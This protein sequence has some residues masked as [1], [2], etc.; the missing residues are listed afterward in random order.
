MP[1]SNNNSSL[2][3]TDEQQVQEAIIKRA[4]S[5]ISSVSVDGMSTSFQSLDTQLK[6]L[7]TLKKMEASKNP[8][9]A[10]KLFKVK[11]GN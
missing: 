9:A 5:G 3:S 1:N 8:L 6:A 7:Q 11:S 4:V 2:N 10:I